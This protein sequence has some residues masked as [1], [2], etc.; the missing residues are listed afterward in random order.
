[1]ESYHT[2][3]HQEINQPQA[4]IG[5]LGLLWTLCEQRQQT[6]SA[7]LPSHL[8]SREKA[9]RKSLVAQEKLVRAATVG[10]HQHINNQFQRR[11]QWRLV[12]LLR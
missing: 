7:S 6:I 11:K 3:I 1:M 10:A 8:L 12:K 9:L 4:M 5:P 2:R